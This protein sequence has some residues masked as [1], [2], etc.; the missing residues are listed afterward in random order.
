MLPAALRQRRKEGTTAAAVDCSLL[1]VP[2][3]IYWLARNIE[4]IRK[5]DIKILAIWH[6]PLVMTAAGWLEVGGLSLE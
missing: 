6:N 3:C 1:S 2:V 4:S 5:Q